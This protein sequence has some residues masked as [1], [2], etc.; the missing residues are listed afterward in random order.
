MCGGHRQRRGCAR[1]AHRPAIYPSATRPSCHRG[2]DYGPHN[3]RI[4]SS[5]VVTVT[6]TASASGLLDATAAAWN[7]PGSVATGVVRVTTRLGLTVSSWYVP[8]I[9]SNGETTQNCEPLLASRGPSPPTGAAWRL[10]GTPVGCPVAVTSCRRF[11]AGCALYVYA[12][13]SWSVTAACAA[14]IPSQ[15]VLSF[16]TTLEPSGVRSAEYTQI[17]QSLSV[18][19]AVVTMTPVPARS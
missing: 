15:R 13:A 4:H 14:L 6:H 2:S 11:V 16:G 5:F 8:G 18:G 12:T 19:R 10:R 3:R 17:E 9:C 7:A 1:R